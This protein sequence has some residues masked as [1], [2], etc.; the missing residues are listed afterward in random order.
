MHQIQLQLTDQLYDRARQRA[1][2]AGLA[3]LDEYLVDVVTENLTAETENLD[4]RFTPNVIAH[5]NQIQVDIRAGAKT[6]SESEVDVYL[7]EKAR[8]WRESHPD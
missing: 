6:Y 7:Q 3:N 5:L 1:A 2:E 4:H 8:A